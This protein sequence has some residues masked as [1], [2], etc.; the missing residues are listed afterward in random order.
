MRVA[1]IRPQLDFCGAFKPLHASLDYRVI[2]GL[3]KTF[4]SKLYRSVRQS[5]IF[6]G[7][8]LTANES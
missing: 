5:D 3:Q 7:G 4:C 2:A 6:I 8:R 1:E